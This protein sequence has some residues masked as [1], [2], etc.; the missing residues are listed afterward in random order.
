MA[1]M[2]LDYGGYGLLSGIGQG[3][4]GGLQQFQQGQQIQRQ[5]NQDK[6]MKGL[7]LKQNGLMEDPDNPGNY[8]QTPTAQ[9]QEQAQQTTAK[10]LLR[11]NDPD[12]PMAQ[13]TQQLY[14]PLLKKNKIDPETL[15][16][17]SAEDQRKY[18]AP[19]IE[20]ET[21][22]A[23]TEAMKQAYLAMQ[24]G[25]YNDKQETDAY[26]KLTAPKTQ[27][28]IAQN[29]SDNAPR[30]INLIQEAQTP[31][32]ATARNALSTELGVYISGDQRLHSATVEAMGGKQGGV[33]NKL[34]QWQNDVDSGTLNPTTAQAMTHFIQSEALASQA[35]ADSI[36]G[37]AANDFEQMHGRAPR[38]APS[39]NG[40]GKGV[41]N[42]GSP[43]MS[44]PTASTGD[45]RI[46]KFI[47]L[48]KQQGM[49]DDAIQ[50]YIAKKMGVASAPQGLLN[51]Q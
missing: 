1:V 48:A 49:S 44:S 36:K 31:E 32:G 19:I 4:A 45:P 28:T 26:N 20:R 46:Q 18:V 14:T 2:P 3:L 22:L 30:L 24:G 5:A 35:E 8:T 10:G 38:W 43:G 37:R 40:Q 23:Q 42:A 41:L 27:Y 15:S 39:S 17:L 11:A 16:G 47:G 34:K 6:L 13:K 29:K 25:K 12:D 50:A 9:L 33:F 51:A 21:Q 7:L